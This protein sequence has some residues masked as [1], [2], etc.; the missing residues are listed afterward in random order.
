MYL[1]LIVFSQD[2]FQPKLCSG[3]DITLDD[4]V[5]VAVWNGYIINFWLITKIEA[6]DSIKNTYQVKK[7]DNYDNKIFYY[8]D[9]K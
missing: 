6:V 5:V 8:G 9:V 7:V 3:H 1:P 4:D 2:K